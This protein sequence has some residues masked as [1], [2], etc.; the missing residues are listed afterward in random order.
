MINISERLRKKFEKDNVWDSN[1][2]Y[3]RISFD[4]L[5]LGKQKIREQKLGKFTFPNF[6]HPL[7]FYIS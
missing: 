1:I 3:Q 7:I 5:K 6:L 2:K 4:I